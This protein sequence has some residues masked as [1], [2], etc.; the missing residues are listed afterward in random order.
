MPQKI[1]YSKVF[2]EQ[3]CLAVNVNLK[4]HTVTAKDSFNLKSQVVLEM[5]NICFINL[6]IF[7]EASQCSR[8]NIYLGRQ[9]MAMTSE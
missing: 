3:L 8:Y 4:H 9:V 6:S 5:A 7:N 2:K 1:T